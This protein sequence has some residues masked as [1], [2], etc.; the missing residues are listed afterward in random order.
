MN[1]HTAL[2]L[3]NLL[4]L[5]SPVLAQE[6]TIGS[7][8]IVRCK[9]VPIGT[10][11]TIG[12]DTYEV[13]DRDLLNQ[14]REETADL[15]KVCVSNIV[16]MTGLFSG[17]SSFND[18]ISSWDVSNVTYMDGMFADASSFNQD[19]GG[20][21]VSNVTNMADMFF[22]AQSFN[23]DIGGWDVSNVTNMFYMFRGAG[24][25]NQD[26]G[27]WD[28]SNVINMMEMFYYT[29]FNQ[30]IGSWDVSNVT[31]MKGMFSG[32]GSFNQDI[33][34]WDLSNVTDTKNMFRGATAFNQD[35]GGW[36]VSNVTDMG[37]MFNGVTSF[38]QDLSSWCVR[39]ITTIPDG[40][41][42][43][44]S[45]ED[46]NLPVWGTCP[47]VPDQ[48]VLSSPPNNAE[49]NYSATAFSWEPDSLATKYNFQIVTAAGASV[50]DTQTV[51]PLF[52][53]TSTIPSQATY[54]WRVAAVNE[55]KVVGGTVATGDWSEVRQFTTVSGVDTES[56]DLPETFVL[57]AAYPN[58]F[59][60]TTTVTYGLPV[61]AEV[62][63]TATDLLGRQVA[64]LVAG[65]MKAAGYHTVQFNADGL[66]SGTYLIR[67]EAGDF[68]AT[69]QVVLL[70]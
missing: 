68:V 9:D 24:S 61:A 70:K 51:E 1:R 56:F 44:S 15:S 37:W 36:D 8:G 12:F 5:S 64:T 57:K 29:P 62:R 39:L 22:R 19:I 3:L 35:I 63:I 53:P 17:K 7:D 13:V 55:N 43:G 18:D 41:R 32:A 31:N 14:R 6:I 23:Q 48:V 2:I 34:G 4:L 66:A 21:D 25:F 59:N 11:Q 27:S 16:N 46:S 47:G 38:N 40:F 30:D 50:V 26:I 58:P 60:P 49:V 42:F 69:Q 52:T 10:T 20:W 65:D 45:L 28:V 67:M 54:F 33:G